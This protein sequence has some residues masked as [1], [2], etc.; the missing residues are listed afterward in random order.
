MAVAA[1][2]LVILGLWAAAPRG[3]RVAP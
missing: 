1:L 3:A 2:P